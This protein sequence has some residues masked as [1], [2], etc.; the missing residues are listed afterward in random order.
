LATVVLSPGGS[1]LHWKALDVDVGS[2]GLLLSSADRSERLR[3]L[4]R[5]AVAVGAA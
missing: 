2:P 4:A 3:E 5:L 1:V